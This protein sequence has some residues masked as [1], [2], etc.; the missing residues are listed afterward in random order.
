MIGT[1]LAMVFDALEYQGDQGLVT[2]DSPSTGDGRAYIWQEIREKF[3]MDAAFFHGNLPVVYFKELQSVDDEYLRRLH[4]SLWNHNRAPLLIAVL[5]QEVRVYN[6]FAPPQR[7]SDQLMLGNATPLRQA[8]RQV[9]D[10]LSLRQELSE[11]GRREIVA[12][13]FVRAQ[14]GGFN[15]EHRVDK[16]LL[17]NLRQVRRRLINDGLSKSVANSLLGRSIFVRYL[18]D[19]EVIDSDYFLRFSSGSSFHALLD[20]S[21]AETY[22]LFEELADRFNGDLFPIDGPERDQVK[23]KHLRL[24]GRFLGGEEVNSGQMYFWAYDFKYIPIELISAIYET[25]LDEER[26]QASAYYTPPEIVDY[27][28]NEVLPFES[29]AQTIKILDP[30]CGS[31]IFLVEAYRR[32]VMLHRHARGDQNLSFDE[33]RDLLTECIHGI[34]LNGEAVQ[35]AAFSCYLALLEFLE[36]KSIWEEVR[37]P[38]L[39]GTNLFVNDF[40]DLDAPFNQRLYDIIVGNPPWQSRLTAKAT[41]YVRENKHPIGDKQIAQAFLWRAPTLLADQGRVSLLSP[42]KGVL[43]NNNEPNRK[44][45]QQFFMTNQVTQVVDFSALRHSLFRQ[46]VGP[47][48]AVFYRTPSGDDSGRNSF[49]YLNPHPSPMSEALAGVV[50]FGDEVRRLSSNQ[51]ASHPYIWKVALWG[52]PRDLT[53]IDDLCER[54]PSLERV[55]QS[56]RWQFRAGLI[57]NGRGVKHVPELGAMRYVPVDSVRPFQVTSTPEERIDSEDFHRPRDIETYQGPHVLIRRGVLTSGVLASVFMQDDAVFTNGIFGITGP[58][59]DSENLKIVCAYINSSLA[60]YYQFLTASQWGVERDEILLTEHK[61]LPCAIPVADE[62]LSRGIVDLV[63][64][65]QESGGG[66]NWQQ[67]LDELVYEAYGVTSHEQQTIEDFLRM[68][69]ERH[70]KGSASDAFEAPSTV[71]LTS[72]AQAFADVFEATTGGTRA[73]V[74]TVYEGT[75]PYRAISFRLAPGDA[76]RRRHN[77][78]SEPELDRLLVNLERIVT[79]QHAQSL[80]FRRNI[81]V[82]EPDVFHMVKPAERRFWT[83]SAAYN[84]ADETIVELLRSLSPGS[85]GGAA[86]SI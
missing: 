80:Y 84:D 15:R 16:R 68:A 18:E 76:P 48:V 22:R 6:C 4:R 81:K 32:L 39:K 86:H 53:L 66:W 9:T 37:F 52:T 59:E 10:V 13:R 54:F 21:L 62:G 36:P 70:Y 8:I 5:P 47:M 51:A 83:R 77:I 46:A 49:M 38:T 25:F 72:Y 73:L 23:L 33:L 24:L 79:E 60:R 3:G 58:P 85:N 64:R 28:L 50:V 34:D 14:Q 65:I 31:G 35:V 57:V 74:P 7:S 78:A 41:E 69:M 56:R 19:R 30:A 40:F 17:E 55:T 12:G 67:E 1:A 44:F 42:S 71:E 2:V 20:G 63:D 27:V 29:G 75:P 11:Y 43:F 45:R 61:S 82:Y 26:N